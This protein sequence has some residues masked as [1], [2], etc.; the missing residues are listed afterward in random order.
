MYCSNHPGPFNLAMITNQEAHVVYG[1]RYN[2]TFYEI[3]AFGVRL[4]PFKEQKNAPRFLEIF[5]IL[6][7]DDFKSLFLLQSFSIERKCRKVKLGVDY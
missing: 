6:P 5:P 2:R 7:Y 4:S 3:R 1:N